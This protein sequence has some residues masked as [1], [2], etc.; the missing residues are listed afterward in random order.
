VIPISLPRQTQFPNLPTLLSQQVRSLVEELNRLQRH[1]NLHV[2]IARQG[3][4]GTEVSHCASFTHTSHSRS[5]MEF[6]N[7]LIE[8]PNNDA[9]G[10]AD[11]LCICHKQIQSALVGE[12]REQEADNSAMWR[13]VW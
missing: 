6:A 9:L 4:D 13:N 7:M 10:Y 12:K 2:L 8:D 5:Q 3:V 1:R 11:Y